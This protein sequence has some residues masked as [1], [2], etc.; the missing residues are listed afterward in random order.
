MKKHW[1]YIDEN[2]ERKGPM[3]FD[4]IKLRRILRDTM[5]WNESMSDWDKA[6][7]IAE[8]DN[9]IIDKIQPPP[10]SEKEDKK[11]TKLK[12]KESQDSSIDTPSKFTSKDAWNGIL[13]AIL[14]T[15]VLFAFELLYEKIFSE[16]NY[17]RRVLII[18]VICVNHYRLFG[19]YLR[20]YL[21]IC[22][23][24]QNANNFL[25]ITVVSFISLNLIQIFYNPTNLFANETVSFLDVVLIILLIVHVVS[26]IGLGFKLL[27]INNDFSGITK[28]LGASILFSVLYIV[29]ALINDITLNQKEPFS[30]DNLWYLFLTNLP[31]LIMIVMFFAVI[32]KLEE[33]KGS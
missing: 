8:L 10:L 28:A 16:D 26:Y 9:F 13:A 23:S 27:S 24:Y 20:K 12:E 17:L 3:S 4:E 19:K 25:D 22:C 31:H 6:E 21:N 14:L 7:N 2:N 29:Y 5:V 33:E 18:L 15:V 32:G 1:Y 30:S 11:E